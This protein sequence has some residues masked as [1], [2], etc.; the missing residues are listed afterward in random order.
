MS[1]N[2][3]PHPSV[4][5]CADKVNARYIHGRPKDLRARGSQDFGVVTA[6]RTGTI[7]LPLPPPTLPQGTRM[8]RSP[9]EA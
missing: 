3:T 5:H 6:A 2:N 4:K 1:S 7:P 9:R 8:H